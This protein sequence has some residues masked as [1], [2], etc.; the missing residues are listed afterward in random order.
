VSGRACR[1]VLATALVG[2]GLGLAAPT[3]A[4]GLTLTVRAVP[5][6]QGVDF[7]FNGKR[8][9]TSR[10]G[11]VRIPV[12]AAGTYQITALPWRHEARGIRVAFSR[13]GDDSFTRSRT[14][15]LTGDKTLQSGYGVSYL[16]GLS[17]YDCVTIE[18]ETSRTGCAGNEIRSVSRQRVTRAVLANI[19]GEKFV[20]RSN[21]RAW[22]EGLRV[23]RRLNGLEPTLITYSVLHVRVAGS[24]VV[25]QAQQ[26][27]YLA[28]PGIVTPPRGRLR[29]A[30]KTFRIRLSLYDAHF[31]TYDLLLRKPIGK[32]L[33][34]TYPDGRQQNVPLVD[35]KAVL[36]SMPRGLYN[37][38]VKTGAG[39]KMQV[40]LS[41][42]RNQN[43]QLKVIS[44]VDLLGSFL[45]FVLISVALVTAR[46]PTL[47]A[48][49]RAWFARLGRGFRVFEARR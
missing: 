13:W 19:I 33:L 18:N 11:A 7:S 48:A 47:R 1:V 4:A 22:L 24:D 39:I 37:V 45:V 21:Q 6:L 14:V 36:T 41:L 2:L 38:V 34:L 26:R 17:F 8:Y 10:D 28:A 15:R 43:M 32:A 23:A 25:N 3:A 40:P 46:R 12:A 20:L 49:L 16:R 44:Y 31:S 27:Y 35:G 42:S 29:Y 30:G 9:T 5:A